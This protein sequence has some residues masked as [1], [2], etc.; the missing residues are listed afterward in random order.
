MNK[1]KLLT[2]IASL[3]L[4]IGVGFYSLAYFTDEKE[5]VNVITTGNI[6]IELHDL[7]ADGKDF[8]QDDGITG[9][10]PGDKIVKVVKVENVGSNPAW[11]KV[12]LT[13]ESNKENLDLSVI[14]L[15]LNTTQWAK[16]EDGAY[17][18]YRALLPGETTENLLSSVTF[19]NTLGNDYAN[20]TFTIGVQAYG[21]QSQNNGSSAQEASW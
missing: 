11:I 2:I 8:P 12:V 14:D 21:V 20:V 10:V 7:G 16:G 4:I 6:A 3:A 18:Y 17:Y 9:V 15:E 19:P 5:A 1:K 13:P